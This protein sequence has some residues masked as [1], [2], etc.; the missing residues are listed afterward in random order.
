MLCVPSVCKMLLQDWTNQKRNLVPP[1]EQ[2][3]EVARLF[4]Q[5]YFTRWL[6]IG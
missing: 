6:Y 4:G 2:L 3:G 5:L 1:G